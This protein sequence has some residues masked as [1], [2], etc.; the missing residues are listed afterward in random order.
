M[1]D[2][3]VYWKLRPRPDSIILIL[4]IR[5]PDSRSHSLLELE[6]LGQ[7]PYATV[8]HMSANRNRECIKIETYL[9]VK[10]IDGDAK[11]ADCNED[12]QE[13]FDPSQ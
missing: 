10:K 7:L 11:Q 9:A 12:S 5:I 4:I 13:L 8:D 1:V 2:R 6:F 3:L